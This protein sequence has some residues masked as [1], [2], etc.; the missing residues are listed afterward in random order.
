MGVNETRQAGCN[1]GKCKEAQIESMK[2]ERVCD[3]RNRKI[4]KHGEYMKK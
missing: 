2:S 1:T 3:D 4:K